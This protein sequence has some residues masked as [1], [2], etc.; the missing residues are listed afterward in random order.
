MERERERGKKRSDTTWLC[1]TEERIHYTASKTSGKQFNPPFKVMWEGKETFLTDSPLSLFSGLEKNERKSK[2]KK[3]KKEE[4]KRK[5][6]KNVTT[7]QLRKGARSRKMKEE[8]ESK[9]EDRRHERREGG[10]GHVTQTRSHS[11]SLSL[12]LSFDPFWYCWCSKCGREMIWNLFLFSSSFLPSFRDDSH[13]TSVVHLFESNLSLPLFTLV[14]LFYY[15]CLFSSVT[16]LPLFLLRSLSL[17]F[18]HF[19]LFLLTVI[20]CVSLMCLRSEAASSFTNTWNMNQN[21]SLP[22]SPALFSPFFLSLDFM[23]TFL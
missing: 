7:F 8:R 12:F 19:S 17:S 20:S 6:R 22:T 5:G 13:G 15:S 2:R 10:E 4:E 23:A 3:R 11:L 16:L 14:S 9:R 18:S 21:F 1:L